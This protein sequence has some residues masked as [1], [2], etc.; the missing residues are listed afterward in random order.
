MNERKILVVDD[1]PQFLRAM[2][3]ALSEHG[4]N[5]VA[6]ESGEAALKQLDAETPDLVLLDMNLPGMNGI[7]TC[8]A[9]RAASAVP[10]IMLSVRN[11]ERDKASA[12]EAGANAYVTKPF[13][14]QDL[15]DRIRGVLHE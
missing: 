9:I 11:A 3:L 15:L 6:A 1:E 7:E 8:Q 12:L 13:G 4:F 14:M 5:A 2:R 10:V